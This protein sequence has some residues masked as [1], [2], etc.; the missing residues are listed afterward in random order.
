MFSITTG[1]TLQTISLLAYLAAYKGIWGPHLVVVPTS[2]IL[3]WETELKRFCPGLKALCYYGSAKR[4]KELRSGWTKVSTPSCH[5]SLDGITSHM[6]PKIV[7]LVSRCNHFVSIGCTGF[8]CIQE[9]ALVLLNSR[10]SPEHKEFSNPTLANSHQFQLAAKALADRHTPAGKG[11]RSVVVNYNVGKLSHTG[12][13]RFPK[14]NLM[15]LWSLL[16]FLMP[17]IFRS[18]KDFSFWFSNPMNSMIEGTANQNDEMITRL[19]GIIRPFVL[20][21]LK[22]DVETQ[23][24]GKFEHVVKCPLSRRQVSIHAD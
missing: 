20:R 9:K 4:R 13:I 23:L 14:N 22:N 7:R 18:R 5:S 8:V 11:D 1:K 19:H 17:Y 24:P 3:N 16:H 15:E 12:Y 6:E 10:R 2:V 21:R